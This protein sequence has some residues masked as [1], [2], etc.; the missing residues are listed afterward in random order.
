MASRIMLG[1]LAVAMAAV[2]FL[3]D[4]PWGLTSSPR[5]DEIAVLPDDPRLEPLR[6][7][8]QWGPDGYPYISERARAAAT[9]DAPR[10]K[11]GWTYR[12]W[13][14]LGMPFAA[15]DE[16]GFVA[17]LELRRGIKLAILD[18]PRLDLLARITGRDPTQG[19]AFAAW[20]H[21][22]GWLIV[23]GLIVWQIL[24]SREIRRARA[25][26][27]AADAEPEQVE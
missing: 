25:A 23:L 5:V 10:L 18:Q 27:R 14:I 21:V 15:Y 3:T 11:L 8:I 9:S 19:Y 16:S 1:L 22:W 4:R 2:M 24:G 12:E 6:R 17:F 13:N 7:Q 20:R 26:E